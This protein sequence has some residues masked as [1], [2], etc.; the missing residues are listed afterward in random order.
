MEEALEARRQQEHFMDLTSHEMRN[1]LGAVVNCSDAL[2]EA[3]S[4]VRAML[5]DNLSNDG[6]VINRL[7]ELVDQSVES[8][9]T[10]IAC[11]SHQLR[12]ADDVLALSKLD[13]KLLQLAPNPAQVISLLSDIKKS[14]EAEAAN[15]L[16]QLVTQVDPS[17]QELKIDWIMLDMGRVRQILVNLTS[18]A[19]KFSRKRSVRKVTIRMGASVSPP[20]QALLGVN[21]VLSKKSYEQSRESSE[22]QPVYLYF[23]VTDTGTGLTAEQ[24][25]KLFSRF[26]Q[27]SARTYNDYGGSGLGL[28]ISQQL[29]EMQGGMIGLES[30]AGIGS[31]F[32][33][34]VK[35]YRTSCPE[36]LKSSPVKSSSIP[37]T[38]MV[39]P[40]SRISVLVVEDNVVNQK[41][42]KMQLVKHGYQVAVADNGQEALDFIR[43]TRHWRENRNILDREVDLILMDVEMPILD[44]LSATR[45]IRE[46]EK[47]GL[48]CDHIPIVAVSANA[49]A[50]QMTQAIEAGMD[51]T[52]TKPFRMP[53]LIKKVI[54]ITSAT[55]S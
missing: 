50:E 40:K 3:L 16:V 7:R 45:E 29:C 46:Y 22:N 41:I 33:F 47:N 24:K 55:A 27:A 44:G 36:P 18:N 34:F 2:L 11:S 28:C 26:S 52:I 54:M 37:R 1:P 15:Q 30:Q 43:S 9:N 8:T 48:I 6:Q 17:L 31:T 39:H 23:T 5:S 49:R 53:D 20:T 21:F 14:Y 32:A 38:D 12:I 19:L 13:S 10:I 4:E 25:G 35:A 42:M 51:D